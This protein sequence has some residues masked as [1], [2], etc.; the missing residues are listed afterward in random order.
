MSDL[1]HDLE[2]ALGGDYT[3]ERELGGGGMSRVFVATDRVLRREVVVKV[4]PPETAGQVSIER[5]RREISLAARLQHPHIVPLL[6]AGE[7]G[8]LPYFTM[9]Y[10]KGES[11]RAKLAVQGEL[12]VIEAVRILREIASAL[13]FA[14]DGGVVHRDIKPDNVL[15]SGGSAMV[16]DFGVAKAIGA[17]TAD[18]GGTVTS[19]GIALGTPA[20]MSPEQASADPT[21][22]HRADIYAWGILAYEMLSG[23]T[24][25]VGRSSSSLLAA[26]VIETPEAIDKRR[27][28]L[29]PALSS[30]VMRC[31]D[32]RPADRPQTAL[33]LMRALD[34]IAPSGGLQPTASLFPTR[35][36]RIAPGVVALLVVAAVGAW[37][38]GRSRVSSGRDDA[39]AL[40]VLP[41]EAGGGDSS[42]D[43]LAEG[44]SDEVRSQLTAT[45]GLRV[46]ARAS[47]MAFRGRRM[48][49]ADVAGK[50][51]VNTVLAGSVRAKANQLFVTAE[52]V[53]VRDGNALWSHTFTVAA[54]SLAAVQD[55]ITHAIAEALRFP[56]SSARRTEFDALR[57][58]GTSDADAYSLFLKGA[59]HLHRFAFR[60]AADNLHGA[61]ARDPKFAR[62]WATLALT[63]A[64][65]TQDGFAS[66]DSARPLALQ[67]STRA[68][69]LD[70]TLVDA[71][72]ARGFA[73]LEVFRLQAA[74]SAFTRALDLLPGDQNALLGRAQ[75]QM[76][77]GDVAASLAIVDSA[78]KMDPLSTDVLVLVQYERFAASRFR[79]AIAATAPILELDPNSSFGLQ[80]LALAY[81]FLGKRDSAIATI[82]HEW[83]VD[84]TSFGG[85]ESAL[86]VYAA[87]G[88]WDRVHE[89]QRRALEDRGNSPHFARFV[90]RMVAGD[91]DAAAAEAA[92]GI[93]SHEPLFGIVFVGCDPSFDP[94]KTV[95]RYI[96]LMKEIG[97]T[98]CPPLAPWPITPPR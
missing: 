70:S 60:D 31:L 58:R 92:D 26:H 65:M 4:L 88:R 49:L 45:S 79:E 38:F 98:I 43:Y 91:F 53:N 51:G 52:L 87:T 97:V 56:S 7:A 39:R 23:S 24:P 54:A 21:V 9:P 30:L 18:G 77:R 10:V 67:Y 62:A 95:P 61:V 66:P 44:L 59:Y 82:D 34:T 35:S 83:Q 5:F 46:K 17:S 68:L 75:V 15:L 41:F 86:I 32:K 96:A 36:R 94:M 8:S 72:D 74:D 80:N 63:Y 90:S 48:E 37:Y 76:H 20:Y 11:L 50:L 1:Q 55:S 6:S 25:F 64:L 19:L 3:I 22:D 73:Q 27:A 16:T 2:T 81:A 71:Y 33:D 13:A 57:Q 78:R 84:S 12:P 89:L 29:P 47:S 85:L 28:G 93:H 14:H 69:E 42:F 40:A